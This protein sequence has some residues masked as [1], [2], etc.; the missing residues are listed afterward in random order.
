MR[1]VRVLCLATAL[2]LAVFACADGIV[3]DAAG[4][5]AGPGNGDG[6]TD[7]GL[8][9]G[10]GGDGGG[11]SDGGLAIIT[12]GADNH[13][14]GVFVDGAFTRARLQALAANGGLKP[15]TAFA[16]AIQ[17]KVYASP[18]FVERGVNG[19]D[20]LFVATEQNHVYAID[21]M[22]GTILWD[23]NLGPPVPLSQL[24]CGN[25]DPM[26]VTGTPIICPT[27]Q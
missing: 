13:R 4:G 3:G 23:T 17:G 14:D 18:L 24:G 9:G 16:P 8:D 19:K 20:A 21:P 5:G 25:I 2:S 1:D 15:D 6:G 7:G 10:G 22:T 26:G 11:G 12:F 27:I